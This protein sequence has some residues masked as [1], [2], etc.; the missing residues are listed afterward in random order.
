MRLSMRLARRLARRRVVVMVEGIV[1]EI[2]YI[3]AG[4]SMPRILV[5]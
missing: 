5:A 1:A 4:S 3:S 2:H